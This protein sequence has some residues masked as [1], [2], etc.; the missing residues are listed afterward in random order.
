MRR[1]S[2]GDVVTVSWVFVVAAFHAERM[3]SMISRARIFVQPAM[4][5]I[6]ARSPD[7]RDSGCRE[8]NSYRGCCSTLQH[9]GES[10]STC[11]RIASRS[12]GAGQH[13]RQAPPVLAEIARK[14]GPEQH[15]TVG[16]SAIGHHARC[17]RASA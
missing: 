2:D 9:V 16:E 10:T 3:K 12:N 1:A 4:R 6:P 7:K 11:G 8:R 17:I 5:L 14:I 15:Q 13:P